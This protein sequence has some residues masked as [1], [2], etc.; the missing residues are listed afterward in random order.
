MSS[1]AMTTAA[2]AIACLMIGTWV[3]SLA[4]KNASIVDIV[5]GLGFVI[6]AWAVSP[7]STGMPAARRCSSR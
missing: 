4:L 7:A 3:V 6:V 1:T 2:V 5:W